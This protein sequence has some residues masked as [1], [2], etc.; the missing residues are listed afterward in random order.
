[1]KLWLI[2]AFEHVQSEYFKY[3]IFGDIVVVYIYSTLFA[4]RG[5]HKNTIIIMRTKICLSIYLA[6]F[7]SF[8]FDTYAHSSS[9]ACSNSLSVYSKFT[10]LYKFKPQPPILY[11]SSWI[12][13]VVILLLWD[14]IS[15]YSA[16]STEPQLQVNQLQVNQLQVNQDE[17]VR[18]RW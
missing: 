10:I 16:A 18:Q 11:S 3:L 6:I 1:M 7:I 13:E 9:K 8:R 15:S 14:C 2:L 5:Q 4:T 12:S 17:K